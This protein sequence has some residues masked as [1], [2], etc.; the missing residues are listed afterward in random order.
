MCLDSSTNPECDYFI[1]D[2]PT[3]EGYCAE[4][5]VCLWYSWQKSS[6]SKSFIRQC[7]NPS[8]VLGSPDQPLLVPRPSCQPQTISDSSDISACLCTSDLC[9]SYKTS[10]EKK[11]ALLPDRRPKKSRPVPTTKEP[12][13]RPKPSPSQQ[14]SNRIGEFVSFVFCSSKSGLFTHSAC[15]N[16][17]FSNCRG[18]HICC[19]RNPNPNPGPSSAPDISPGPAGAPVL[20]LRQP[21]Q[22]EQEV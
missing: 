22:P 17:K 14:S 7:F 8:I 15:L 5:E 11:P 9:N 3:Q 1:E 16:F 6:R 18:F 13:R 21:P 12:N 10:E 19:R 2:D 20:Q 4:G